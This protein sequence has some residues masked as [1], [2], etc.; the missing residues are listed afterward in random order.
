MS[1]DVNLF[2][3]LS[4]EVYNRSLLD[5]PLTV[6]QI[7]EANDVKLSLFGNVL[8]S[9]LR[10]AGFAVN[11]ATGLIYSATGDGFAA[12]IVKDQTGKYIVVFRGSD[13]NVFDPRL[14]TASILGADWGADK[15][16]ALGIGSEQL[17]D[18]QKL[19][20]MVKQVA[21]DLSNVI[22][23]GHSLGGGLAGLISATMGVQS[24]LFDPAPFEL[25]LI[26]LANTAAAKGDGR[27]P[28]EVR[29]DYQNNLD[30]F[31]HI[32]TIS[33]EALSYYSPSAVALTAQNSN[34][35][36]LG[37]GDPGALHSEALL[38]LTLVRTSF[39]ELTTSDAALR[40]GMFGVHS[41][42]GGPG[43]SVR[44][45]VGTT[46]NNATI[47]AAYDGNSADP[48]ILYRALLQSNDFYSTFATRFA[49][50]QVGAA[51][52]G[53]NSGDLASNTVH[54]GLVRLG[55]ETIKNSLK[56]DG[57][58]D[59]A[60][61]N[62]F[63]DVE[64]QHYAI[65]RL[66]E[67]SSANHAL[68]EK[69]PGNGSIP[70]TFHPW[71]ER[72]I[73][74]AFKNALDAA[75]GGALDSQV[76][77]ANGHTLMKWDV[78][79][80]EVGVGNIASGHGGQ[81]LS[82]TYIP[83]AADN[84]FGNVIFGGSGADNITASYQ[85]DYIV[86][87]GGNDVYH[88]GQSIPDFGDGIGSI[89]VG[90]AGDTA[91][92][93]QSNRPVDIELGSLV[94]PSPDPDDTRRDVL[95]GVTNII[96]S[97]QNDTLNLSREP[98]GAMVTANLG[99]GN[100]VIV[101]SAAASL[102]VDGGSG[103]N[104]LF[105]PFDYSTAVIAHFADPGYAW[106]ITEGSVVYN[107]NDMERFAFNNTI[108]TDGQLLESHGGLSMPFGVDVL[109][110]GA[111]NQTTT[112]Y[113]E[114]FDYQNWTN[115]HTCVV[116]YV[117]TGTQVGALTVGVQQETSISGTRFNPGT[118]QMSYSL[119][120]TA[121]ATAP[122]GLFY[123]EYTV[124][125][126]DESGHAITED[127]AIPVQGLPVNTT[128]VFAAVAS[129]SIT[130]SSA[131]PGL[132][133]ASG[134]IEF[135]D[136]DFSD[137]HVARVTFNGAALGLAP[138]GQ[139]VAMVADDTTG[140]GVGGVIHWTYKVDEAELQTLSDG[141]V[142]HET[143]SIFIDDGLGGGALQSV[144]LTIAAKQNTTSITSPGGFAVVAKNASPTGTETATGTLNF[145]DDNPLD[146]HSLLV[147]HIVTNPGVDPGAFNA[148]IDSDTTDGAAGVIRWSYNVDDAALAG[149]LAGHGISSIYE[150]TVDDGRGGRSGQS[151]FINVQGA[152]GA[153]HLP[154]VASADVEAD[155]AWT[156]PNAN[157][158]AVGQIAFNDIDIGDL[159]TVSVTRLGGGD[160]NGQ[161]LGI[162]S[163][164]I[165]NDTGGSG[166]G[167]VEWSYLVPDNAI[168]YLGA[169]QTTTE[170]FRV[171]IDDGHGGTVSQ[172]VV[173]N[174]TGS[175]HPID[176]GRDVH[177]WTPPAQ[178]RTCGF[179]AYGSHLGCLTAKRS[180]GQG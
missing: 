81:G 62:V 41:Q 28:A 89:V 163:V 165:T 180:L 124:T 20:G 83:T 164:H 125:V 118:L 144:V 48:G 61:I 170:T 11:E 56:S 13:G 154:S 128:N 112:F 35:I 24:Y 93:S 77:V 169:G 110:V 151:V 156:A 115:T 76:T 26:A 6:P 107:V 86:G 179:P 122:K 85:R 103:V 16:L 17:A 136:S 46:K 141:V 94:A 101:A 137:A 78:L 121:L 14:S 60:G 172:D 174:I 161:P 8:A 123:E 120:A 178:I 21:G 84:L 126:N 58:I 119:D 40:D 90:S 147:T 5:R 71:G 127:V 104:W 34:V 140:T 3:E 33:G 99:G 49:D 15:N 1:L 82:F 32:T 27:T 162:L 9:D 52:I 100:D 74:A 173:A 175:T 31:A 39:Q 12:Q 53:L 72:D 55:L 129:G 42:I 36:N 54:T 105:I 30:T 97:A 43:N 138:L 4:E 37:S 133:S 171:M 130:E 22:V 98:A 160:N 69:W 108:L 132:Q 134:M 73:D 75:G 109:T 167:I 158:V 142:A 79:V 87:G 66:S 45:D 44:T 2:A 91:D 153:E 131:T 106:R 117:G 177:Y 57:T 95:I 176:C 38:A 51:G 116:E 113:D 149:L 157:E 92:Y 102:N 148:W 111:G 59:A 65:A 150:V 29:G 159:H 143:Y 114:F 155:V 88:L 18:A 68:L 146:Q 96:G 152:N 63:G 50:I 47:T 19:M 64:A 168:A 166:P 67:S 139:F 145:H 23:T 80:A 25:Q 70:S 10:G 7:S 135:A